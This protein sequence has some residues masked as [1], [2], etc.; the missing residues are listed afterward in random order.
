MGAICIYP[1]KISRLVTYAHNHDRKPCK[2][3]DT[4]KNRLR[5]G[6]WGSKDAWG[7]HGACVIP[8]QSFL[9]RVIA[10]DGQGWEHVAVSLPHRTPHWHEMCF[11]KDVFWGGEEV[12]IQ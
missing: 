6:Q 4:P 3:W 8:S 12:V 7:N 2:R 9:L 5:I 10:S 1:N 11:V